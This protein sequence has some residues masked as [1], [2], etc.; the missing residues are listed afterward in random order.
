MML[1]KGDDAH[2]TVCPCPIPHFPP[3][4]F[5]CVILIINPLLHVHLVRKT[6]VA[7]IRESLMPRT[8]SGAASVLAMDA[9]K[10]IIDTKIL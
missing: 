6:M 4:S 1:E 10:K 8:H 9:K 7:T 3:S 2:H 5:W